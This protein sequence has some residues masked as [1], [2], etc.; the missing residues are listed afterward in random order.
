MQAGCLASFIPAGNTGVS[1]G[2]LTI[3]NNGNLTI[4]ISG[5]VSLSNYTILN[6]NVLNLLSP[7]YVTLGTIS[8]T[9][10]T[11]HF[12]TISEIFYL[13]GGTLAGNGSVTAIVQSG[14]V[15]E[16]GDVNQIGGIT[17]DGFLQTGGVIH[18]EISGKTVF[19]Q[20]IISATPADILGGTVNI[21]VL[22]GFI[23][24]VNGTYFAGI[25]LAPVGGVSGEYCNGCV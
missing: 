11:T 2:N 19:D 1:F 20:L 13:K 24:G 17:T 4:N 8:Q 10:G 21:S 3:T 23:L 9:M 6:T 25:I 16:P 5:S 15:I 22:K 18:T 7:S 14:G 12:V